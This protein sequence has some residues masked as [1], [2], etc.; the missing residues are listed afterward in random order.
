MI[1]SF[2][3]VLVM[4]IAIVLIQ[5]LDM[6][7]PPLVSLLATASF[8]TVYFNIINRHDLKKIYLDCWN[9]KSKWVVV[10]LIV[11]I[12]W[13]TSMIGPGVLGGSLFNFIYFAWLGMLGFI[14]LSLQN[15]PENRNK[16]YFGI[17]LL[18]LNGINVFFELR[19]SLTYSVIYGLVLALVGGTAS[20]VYFKQSQAL[21]RKAHLS[22][23][24]VLAVRFYLSILVILIFLPKHQIEHYFTWINLINFAMLAFFSL[25]IP[26]YFSQKALEKITSEQHAIVNSLCPLMTGLLQEMF[27]NDVK[28]EQMIIYFVY[29][30]AI[31]CFYYINNYSRRM[32]LS[33]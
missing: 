10:M 3:Y 24:Q 7:I 11:L 16:V 2:L 20:F 9:N 12:M 27:F 29:F 32:E 14:S 1:Y 19:S 6:S 8:A 30:L 23:T 13:S 28:K 17:C 33:K 31:F 26:L 18:V 4:S 22:A 5:K 21:A 15:W 25:I